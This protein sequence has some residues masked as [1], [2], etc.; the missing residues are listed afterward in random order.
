[1]PRRKIELLV[2]GDVRQLDRALG[3]AETRLQSF[4]RS[5]DRASSGRAGGV[6]GLLSLSRGGAFA[7]AGTAIGIGLTK[8]FNAAKE[9]EVVLGQT[10]VAV[11][12][13]GL[14]WETN[15]RRI[16]ESADRISKASAFDDEAVLQS[17]QVFVRSQKDVEKALDLTSLAA[18]V[19]RARYIS[20]E[21]A[22]AI[23]TKAAMGN[24]GALRR[25]GI[26][27]RSGASAVELLTMLQ[28]KYAGAAEQ[29]SSTA[30]GSIDR[31]KTSLENLAE[32]AGGP[33]AEGVTV[34]ADNLTAMADA[35]NRGLG[36]LNKLAAIKIP[37]IHIPLMF[38]IG[39]EGR[40]IG[41]ALFS[42]A[43][44]VLPGLGVAQLLK[45]WGFGGGGE[46]VPNPGSASSFRAGAPG[47][48]G[49]PAP[50]KIPS[51]VTKLPNKLVQD[52]LDAQI[53][54]NTKQILAAYKAQAAFLKRA[55]GQRG[56]NRQQRTDLKND[57]A[58]VLDTI[59]S[60]EEIIAADAAANAAELKAAADEAKAAQQAAR[61]KAR[62]AA[63]DAAQALRDQ[64]DAFK[65]A[66]L[67]RLDWQQDNRDTLRD[68][69]D[70]RKQLRKAQQIG[71]PQGII[72]AR[73]ALEDAELARKRFLV[74][75]ARVTPAA[76]GGFNFAG[77]TFNFFGV[78][79]V[80][81]LMAELAKAGN[82]TGGQTRG[83]HPGYTHPWT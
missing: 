6:G 73:R 4:G 71:G 54:G 8:A 10:S 34:A 48:Q 79:N 67:D 58:S 13:A 56:L 9:A 1:M 28:Q 81:Q 22:T 18:D 42:S 19:A 52:L 33:L 77:A 63:K 3:K 76:G 31:L 7:A 72:E 70:A 26:D 83:R 57:Y 25:L 61:D 47:V 62:Q 15:S 17:F 12:A 66:A 51:L 21:S 35:A 75:N 14:S 40:S 2:T 68:I 27:A 32:E 49:P 30:Q 36:V 74:E 44:A 23:V 64:A 5:V 16:E 24:A 60:I 37:P 69:T 80:K 55:L 45:E 78:Q 11:E 59:R 53:S 39:G 82:R 29:Y 50:P 38:D 46:T 65:Q 43:G 20:L 41:G